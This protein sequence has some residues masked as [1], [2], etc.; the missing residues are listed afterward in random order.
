MENRDG[1]TNFI[2]K[3]GD[4]FKRD[5]IDVMQISAIFLLLQFIWLLD[6]II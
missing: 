6:K 1:L 5:K 4:H 2:I 3:N